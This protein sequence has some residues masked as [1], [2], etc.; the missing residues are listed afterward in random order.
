LEPDITFKTQQPAQE[1]SDF[2]ESFWMLENAAAQQKEIVV[3]PDG[4]FDILFSYAAEEPFHAILRGLDTGPGQHVIPAKQ[5]MF[6]ISFKLLAVEYLLDIKA[7]AELNAARILPDNFWN[8]TKADLNDFEALCNKVSAS[9]LTLIKPDIDSRKKQL[10]DLIYT[11]NGALSVKELSEKV[12]WSSRQINR[13]FNQQFGISLKVY[14]NILRFRASLQ[15][16]KEGQLFPEQD[17]ADQT[18]FI[19]EIKKF[20]GVVPKELSKNTNGRFILLSA[21]PAQ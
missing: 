9:M 18:H 17:F 13:Y 19:K 11:S 20:S 21:L 14:C 3:L 8:I 2:V 10:F 12:F 15:H 7:A 5:V 6:A 16:I 4:R 1:L